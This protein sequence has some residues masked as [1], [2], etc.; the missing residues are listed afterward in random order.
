MARSLDDRL[1]RQVVASAAGPCAACGEPFDED[2]V[3]VLAHQE[4][5]W[6]VSIDCP[7]CLARTIAAVVARLPVPPPAADLVPP[8]RRR[9]SDPAGIGA[10]DVLAVERFLQDFDGDF[11]ALF[12]SE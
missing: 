4:D 7:R 10:D 11:K 12:S 2:S 9:R 8:E 5:L 1:I 6:F 3:G